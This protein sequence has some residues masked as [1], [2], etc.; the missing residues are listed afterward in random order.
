MEFNL[1][2]LVVGLLLIAV[3]WAGAY[4]V[5]RNQVSGARAQAEKIVEQAKREAERAKHKIVLQA[6][7]EWYQKRDEEERRLKARQRK[8]DQIERELLEKEKALNR[9]ESSV[10]QK[11][12]RLSVAERELQEQKEALKTKEMEL[13]RIIQ[14]QNLA[15][16]RVSN[17]NMEEAKAMLLE[18]LRREYRTEA[19]KIYKELVDA[20]R[21]NA[22]KEAR[23]IITMAIERNAADHCVETSVSVVNLPSEE[24]KGRII[25]R[26]GRNIKAFEAATGVKVIVDDTPE[27]V[28]LS[29]FDPVR[30][31]VARIALEK[32]IR[33]NKINPQRIEELVKAAE[34]E[35][36][37]L[38]WRAGNETIARVSVGRMH[39]ELI[40][41]LG[42]LKYRTSYGQNVL[43][44]SEEVATLTGVMAEELKLNAK[45]ARR[46]GLLHDIGKAMSQDMEG[47]HTQIGIEIA[48]KFNEDPVVIN[49]IASHHEDEAATSLIS[50]LVCAA[51][52]ISGARPGARRDTLDGYV[53]RIESL[54]KVADSFDLVSKAYAISAGREV[55]VIVAPEK[56]SDVEADLL[57]N[58]ISNKIQSDL[59]YP[60]QIKVTVIRESRAVSYA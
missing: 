37:K 17:L 21:E 20:A 28:V 3:G 51:D 27:A 11:E 58:E 59:E 54:E 46:A 22:N 12:S 52:A 14:Q 36:D 7:E 23:K 43:Q 10:N 24:I 4:L 19:A 41:I 47:T 26:D 44:H 39:P 30:R 56:V 42:R 53:R 1:L 18:N 13:N 31:E 40:R 38:I 34:K 35:V 6:K 16:S 32:M 33:N 60:G 49:A 55:R 9:K 8:F 2:Y 5:A 15:L 45:L 29:A 25:G 50:V 48:K 57:A